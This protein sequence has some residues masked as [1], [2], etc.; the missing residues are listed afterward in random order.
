LSERGIR[1]AVDAIK[2][3]ALIWVV[4]GACFA[5]STLATLAGSVVDAT[6]AVIPAAKV[7]LRNSAFSVSRETQTT[8]DGNFSFTFLAPG[9]YEL[10]AEKPGFAVSTLV[11][12]VLEGGSQ[13]SVRIPIQVSATGET[14][15]VTGEASIV[16]DSPAVGTVINRQFTENLPLNGRTFQALIGLVPGVVFTPVTF[17]S[18]GSGGGQFSVN[19]QRASA[20]YFVVDGVGANIGVSTIDYLNLSGGA[21]LPGLTAF[22]GTN[23]LA[24]MD[25]LE[26][27]QVLT[28]NFAPE[29][30][31]MPGGQVLITTRSGTNRYHGTLFN[32]FRNDALDANDWFANRAGI[33]RPALRQ[34]DFGGVLGGPVRLPGYDGRERTFFFASYE[35]LRLRQPTAGTVVVPSLDV[36]RRAP[37]GVA[38]F[39]N[40]YPLP[41]GQEFANGTAAFS[42]SYS[43]PAT[44]NATSFRIDHNLDSRNRVFGRFN[45]APST[46]S[47]R[48]GSLSVRE[49]TRAR[50][51]TLT[52]GATQIFSPTVS[53]DLRFNWSD[54][55]GGRDPVA[56]DFGGATIPS[57]SDVLPSIATGK[58]DFVGFNTP[59]L[60]SLNLFSVTENYLRQVNV[61]DNLSWT[62]GT[63]RLQVGFD[64]RNINTALDYFDGTYYYYP[65]FAGLGAANPIP[66]TVLSGITDSLIVQYGITVPLRFNNFSSYVQ[67]V[68]RVS[69]RATLTYGFRWD[70]QP[71]PVSTGSTPLLA[72]TQASNP[73]TIAFAPE[74]SAL[75]GTRWGNFAPRVGIAYDL[76]RTPGR[77]LIVRGGWGM[78]NDISL[79][80][81]SNQAIAYPFN[82]ARTT[83]GVPLPLAGGN[84]AIP[85]AGAPYGV[86]V[87]DPE[88]QMPRTYQYQ[89]SIERAIG[90]A[91][92]VTASYVGAAGRRLLRYDFYSTLSPLLRSAE[93]MTNRATS[94]YN[95]LQLQFRRRFNK[96]LQA[97]ASYTWSHSL[98]DV[99]NE[100]VRA[101][102]PSSLSL[103]RASSDFDLRQTFSGAVSWSPNVTARG[104]RPVLG[105][106]SVDFTQTM[107]TGVPVN[108]LAR[109]VVAA[110]F[111]VRVRPD[112]VPGQAQYIDDP[113]APGGRR[114]N[115]AAFA[116]PPVA[117]GGV[118]IRQGTL[119]RNA[120]R[121]FGLVQTDLAVRRQFRLSERFG[122]QFRA[123]AFNLFNRPSFGPPNEN[124]AS[125]LFG[126]STQMYGRSLGT[127]GVTQGLNP[128]YQA[129]GPRSL[130]LALKLVF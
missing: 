35:G 101:N 61:V 76:V 130:Q 71:P 36:R 4:A 81:F 95:A 118:F 45:Y 110:P 113:N 52:L 117:P 16:S 126:S 23:S 20:N 10:T 108:L 6:G 27:F 9:R 17:G 38:P 100:I 5:Q 66:G 120:L 77:E 127:G 40:A 89:V 53:N 116:Q 106:F 57:R 2:L 72:I 128:L 12:V 47:P 103:D 31:R 65:L 102:T 51:T 59:E 63:H 3:L 50:T 82:I 37:A 11:D 115:P 22:G 97:L 112:A 90:S 94:D 105:G 64:W 7:T 91:Q 96:G 21:V 8:P 39:L 99:S 92:S 19:G 29:H 83:P 69:R 49:D 33:P 34:N 41:N 48:Q 109:N 70:V 18:G 125:G 62:V 42:A 107:R 124:I 119:G 54:S 15:T 129:G 74:G 123:E 32:Y 114:F 46:N 24:S 80:S 67:D 14:V 111:R 44:L 84:A 87:V 56:T 30:G 85:V 88:L 98:D 78:F 25:A 93:V 121:A 75:F 68:W 1:F 60:P 86:S 13:V 122:L 28:S 55:F 104:W 43:V 26:E 58:A 79:G 73:A